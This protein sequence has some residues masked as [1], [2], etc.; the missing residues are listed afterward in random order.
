MN[1]GTVRHRQRVVDKPLGG[2]KVQINMRTGRRSRPG[3]PATVYLAADLNSRHG[4]SLQ[5]QPI[6]R[7]GSPCRQNHGNHQIVPDW[8]AGSATGVQ[9]AE[10][11]TTS[12][13]KRKE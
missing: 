12:G 6:S 7:T 10:R 4:G 8:Y 2:T 3:L 11:T 5:P 1:V 13:V 9:P